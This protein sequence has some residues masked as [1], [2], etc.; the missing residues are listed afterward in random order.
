[1]KYKILQDFKGSQDGRFAE[2][3]IAGTEADLS[4]YLVANADPAWIERLDDS[5]AELQLDN[6]AITTT[7]AK[8]KSTKAK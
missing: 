7:G 3:F 6:K 8:P 1:M 5:Q 4:D 2:D